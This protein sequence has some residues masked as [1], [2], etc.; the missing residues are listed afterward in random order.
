MSDNPDFPELFDIERFLPDGDYQQIIERFENGRTVN[1]LPKYKN[2]VLS[3]EEFTQETK[4]TKPEKMPKEELI[5]YLEK[6]EKQIDDQN[7]K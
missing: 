4:S 7:K 3:V 6:L 5:K 2:K 1:V